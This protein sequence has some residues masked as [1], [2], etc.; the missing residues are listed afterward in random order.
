MLPVT[1]VNCNFNQLGIHPAE[2]NI[3]VLQVLEKGT[4]RADN[5]NASCLNVHT[6]TSGDSD[7]LLGLDEF[8]TNVFLGK[9]KNKRTCREKVAFS[10][11]VENF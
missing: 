1:I 11:A 9:A 10:E 8:H 7:K 6:D 5:F 2:G 4:S 3:D